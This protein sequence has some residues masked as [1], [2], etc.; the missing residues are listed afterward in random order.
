MDIK[1]FLKDYRGKA[2]PYWQQF[3]A[4]WL[5]KSQLIDRFSYQLMKRF[6]DLYPRGKQLRGALT[7]LGYELAGGNKTE[8][9]IKASIGIEIAETA[10]L[11]ADDVFDQDDIR[12]GVPTIHRQWQKKAG[13][14]DK[15]IFGDNMAVV[16]S[17][18]GFQLAPLQIIK[19][20]FNLEDKTKALDFY[21]E[22]IALTGFGEALDIGSSCLNFYNQKNVAGKIHDLKTVQYSTVLPFL[23]GAL[24]AGSKNTMWL[25]NLEKYAIYLGRIF[26]IQDDI[27]GSFGNPKTTGKDNNMDIA[28]ARW[29]GLIET[30]WQKA[31]Q[32]DREKIKKIFLKKVRNRQDILLIKKLMLKYKAIDS[33]NKKAKQYLAQGE[34][35]ITKLD[36]KKDRQ[37][38]LSKLLRFMLTRNK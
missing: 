37:T 33:L 21:F 30:A 19:S 2:K 22:K 20:N 23:F 5:K 34:K 31:N 17:I 32:K 28:M 14:V 10:I 9:I 24:L 7:V 25:K 13:N 18:I 8:E 11:I 35:L 1:D 27:L 26:Q 15:K 6:V 3:L 29:T 36:I 38:I 16:T 4:E 12:R